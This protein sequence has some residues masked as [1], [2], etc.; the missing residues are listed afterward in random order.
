VKDLAKGSGASIV[1][2]LMEREDVTA[3]ENK[4]RK[5]LL[6]RKRLQGVDGI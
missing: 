4:F 5:R 1:I 3:S 6:M 2:D